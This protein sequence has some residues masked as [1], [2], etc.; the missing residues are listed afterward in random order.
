[1]TRRTAHSLSV[2]AGPPRTRSPHPPLAR[3][4]RTGVDLAQDIVAAWTR[5]VPPS[6]HLTDTPPAV[7]VRSALAFVGAMA[8]GV[9][10]AAALSCGGAVPAGVGT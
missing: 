5:P 10:L 4:W 6:E 8:V 2:H 3:A 9:V 7:R 1:M